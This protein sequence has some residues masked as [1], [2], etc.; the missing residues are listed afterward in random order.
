ML[1]IHTSII[2]RRLT[3]RGNNKILRTHP[4]HISSSEEILLCLTRRTLAQLRTN[5]SPFLKAYLHKV[6]AKSHP[7]PLFPLCNTHTWI[8]CAVVSKVR[9][10]RNIP[11]PRKWK[12][13][14]LALLT[15]FVWIWSYPHDA[16]PCHVPSCLLMVNYVILIFFRLILQLYKTNPFPFRVRSLPLRMWEYPH[17]GMPTSPR[18]SHPTQ[19]H[20]LER[21]ALMMKPISVAPYLHPP[22]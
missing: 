22:D 8:S 21:N 2:S 16:M 10:F 3:T 13:S 7:S 1:H 5:K 18:I 14:R 15:L 9:R 4:P 6:D 20:A 19:H 11:M 12:M 17:Q